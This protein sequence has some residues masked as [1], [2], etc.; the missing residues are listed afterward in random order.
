MLALPKPRTSTHGLDS[1]S[2][3]ASR[4]WNFFKHR[5]VKTNDKIQRFGV[6]I[7]PLSRKKI[8]QIIQI[9]A[10]KAILARG[11]NIQGCEDYE[12]T[13]ARMES[14]CT[15]RFCFKV[16]IKSISY[17]KQSNLFLHFFFSLDNGVMTTPKRWIL[18][19]VFTVLCL[20]KSLL[21]PNGIYSQI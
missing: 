17:T 1:F 16:L 6:V 13:F 7:T 11:V 8:Y 12:N 2:Y 9:T 10:F 5:T 4:K 14:D 19:F 20:K 21:I 15:L 3:F 18:S